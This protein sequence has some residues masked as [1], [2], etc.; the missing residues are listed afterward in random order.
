MPSDGVSQVWYADDAAA[1]GDLG[2]LRCWWDS[3]VSMG[4]SYGYFPNPKKSWLVTKEGLETEATEVF[5]G[6]GINVTCTGR[7]YLGSPIGTD[8]FVAE[9]MESK[10]NGWIEEIN[11][12]GEIG[13]SQ[14]HAMF[15]A[16]THG[17]MSRWFFI[18]RTVPGAG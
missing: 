7:P 6:C 13:L 4:P 14:P 17:L 8:E 9:C 11:R 15:A 3:L 12:M 1:M 18:C 5:D 10:V 16:L 2:W